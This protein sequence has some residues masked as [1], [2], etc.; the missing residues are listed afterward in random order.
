VYGTPDSVPIKE[1]HPLKGQ[2]PYSAT[3]I[4]A[5]KICESYQCTFD[6]PVVILRPFNTYGPRQSTRAV[7]P[8]ILTQLLARKRE[9]RLGNLKPRRDLTYVS[10]TAEGFICAATARDVEGATIQLG[11]GTSVSIEELFHACCKALDAEATVVQEEER[12][13]PNKGEVM[14]LLSDPSLARQVLG[15]EP[16]VSLEEGLRKTAKWLDENLHRYQVGSYHV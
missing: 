3:K 14:N 5:D 15:W 16:R 1:T 13:R 9:I 7:L 10:D 11:T 4:S 6:V 12:F 2:S 8:T